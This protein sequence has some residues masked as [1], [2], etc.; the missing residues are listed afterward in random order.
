MT[1]IVQADAKDWLGLNTIPPHYTPG[2]PI[3]F[4]KDCNLG[5]IPKDAF[6]TYSNL[7]DLKFEKTGI[8]YIQEGAFNGID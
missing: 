1:A 3:L 4:M 6:I 7:S 8:R 2:D 5:Y